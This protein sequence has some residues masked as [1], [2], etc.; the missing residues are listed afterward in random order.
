M[1]KL[2][3]I[4]VVGMSMLALA[5]G[6][7]AGIAYAHPDP[8]P[9]LEP[10]V[11][12]TPRTTDKVDRKGADATRRSLLK[13]ALHGEATLGGERHRVVVFQRGVVETVEPTAMTVKSPD[14]FTA[15]YVLNLETRVRKQREQASVSDIKVNDTVRVVATKD[16]STLTA[17]AVKDR[18]Q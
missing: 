17:N 15:S 8:T 3:T 10:T 11:N 16:G 14:G 7:G 5:G 2:G 12:A 4:V 13:R 6:I 1:N 9:S 18:G